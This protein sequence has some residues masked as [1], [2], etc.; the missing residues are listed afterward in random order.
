MG[1]GFASRQNTYFHYHFHLCLPAPKSGTTET[2][3]G[4]FPTK[5]C[6]LQ[7]EMSLIFILSKVLQKAGGAELTKKRLVRYFVGIVRLVADDV[8]AREFLGA[9]V[10]LANWCF[11]S[12]K[13]RVD[14]KDAVIELFYDFVRKLESDLSGSIIVY[15]TVGNAAVPNSNQV[16]RSNCSG[17]ILRPIVG[18]TV[19]VNGHRL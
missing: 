8:E 12:L 5:S 10:G 9:A 11:R 14:L 19:F 7:P 15:D 17:K 3:V 16:V 2:D 6:R 1:I 4:K 18:E 13:D